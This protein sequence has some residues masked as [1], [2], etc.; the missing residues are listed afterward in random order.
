MPNSR[1]VTSESSAFKD[2]R[3]TSRR[4]LYRRTICPAVLA[5]LVDYQQ[6]LP[7]S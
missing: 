3:K 5:G 1:K 2:C 6:V 4:A 7:E